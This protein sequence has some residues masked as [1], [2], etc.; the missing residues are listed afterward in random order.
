[1]SWIHIIN[2]VGHNIINW[3]EYILLI[4]LDNIINW[5]GYILLIELDTILL[6]EFGY[7]LLIELDTYY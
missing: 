7:I 6:I 2:R 5:V 3:V 1:M 4:E